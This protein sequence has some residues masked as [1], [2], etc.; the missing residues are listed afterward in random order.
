MA[1]DNKSLGRFDLI[2]I[3][4]APRG[5]P[6]IE[7]SFDIDAN[8]IVHVTAKDLGT[9]KLQSIKITA[10]Q[11]L[12][13]EEIEKMKKE[14]ELHAEDD[15]KH[16]EEIETVNEAD[17]MVYTAERL[18]DDMKGKVSDEKLD[19]VRKEIEELKKLLQEEKKDA[20][21]IRTKLDEVN[22]KIQDLSIEMYKKVAEEQ[23][24]N[25]GQHESSDEAGNTSSSEDDKKDDNVVDAEFTEKSD[26]N[27]KK[28]G[29]K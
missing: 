5:I 28:K 23:Q 20:S 26:D 29:K 24:K 6:Q 16:K 2:G 17:T 13:D 4:P 10:S 25:Q 12:N 9:G 27:P 8:G 21:K 19:D 14:A 3:P 11:K 15:K 22:K 18:F 1:A 7:V